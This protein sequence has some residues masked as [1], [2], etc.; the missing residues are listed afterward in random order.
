MKRIVYVALTILIAGCLTGP[1]PFITASTHSAVTKQVAE[2]TAIDEIRRRGLVIPVDFETDVRESVY[3]PEVGPATRLFS[4]MVFGGQKTRRIQIY[5]VSIN[6]D[7]GGIDFVNN[8]LGTVDSAPPSISKFRPSSAFTEK[9]AV[10]VATSEL[11]KRA[12]LLPAGYQTRVVRSIIF[13]K[14]G[15]DKHVVFVIFLG[16]GGTRLCQAAINRSTGAIEFVFD[17]RARTMN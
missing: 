13:P 12:V 1:P 6:R 10:Q 3:T 14:K 7:T 16:G 4:V 17:L 8:L 9:M 5:L 11:R 15:E 2:R